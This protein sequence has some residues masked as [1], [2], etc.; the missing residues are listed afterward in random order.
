MKDT[1]IYGDYTSPDISWSE[2]IK[3]FLIKL[4]AGKSV[5]ILNASLSIIDKEEDSFLVIDNIDGGL[6]SNF[7]IK[8]DDYKAIKV[9]QWT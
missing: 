5:I 8:A 9:E 1:K 4:V 6:I 2:C 7:N 3:Q